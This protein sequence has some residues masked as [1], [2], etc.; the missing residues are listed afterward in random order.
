[1]I[2][3]SHTSRQ[4]M[5]KVFIGPCL[6]TYRIVGRRCIRPERLQADL[7]AV[8]FEG[9]G[10]KQGEKKSDCLATMAAMAAASASE[11]SP[12][13]LTVSC[14]CQLRHGCNQSESLTNQS[15]ERDSSYL[16]S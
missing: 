1:M 15:A 16:C 8:Q 9:P 12:W 3:H 4:I 14:S 5:V 6:V 10:Y 7:A 11:L 13:H 2:D